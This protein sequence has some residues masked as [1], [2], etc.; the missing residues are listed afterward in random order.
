MSP[1]VG[2]EGGTLT[3]RG[4]PRGVQ[5]GRSSHRSAGG[6]LLKG[7]MMQIHGAEHSESSDKH[8][9]LA[10]VPSFL[11]PQDRLTHRLARADLFLFFQ[12]DLYLA[13]APIF[14]MMFFKLS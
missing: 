7:V 14:L 9:L 12:R 11:G 6:I 13:M 3:A 2:G 1:F 8:Q 5:V 10:T 4:R